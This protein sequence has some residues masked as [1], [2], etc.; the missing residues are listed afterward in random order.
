MTQ[1]V[2][3]VCKY[4]YLTSQMTALL[5]CYILTCLELHVIYEW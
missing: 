5:T 3:S 1:K 2:Y 4:M